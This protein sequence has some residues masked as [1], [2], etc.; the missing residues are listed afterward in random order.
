MANVYSVQSA[1]SA[2]SARVTRKKGGELFVYLALSLIG[3][4]EARRH[5]LP[6]RRSNFVTEGQIIFLCVQFAR[7]TG[8]KKGGELLVNLALSGL[9]SLA[10]LLDA[11][12]TMYPIF[13]TIAI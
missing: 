9:P 12:Q 8:Q 13:E 5:Q 3:G 6:F 11:K 1:D 4:I 2:D 10:C 7:V